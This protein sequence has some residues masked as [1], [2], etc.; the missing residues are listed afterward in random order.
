MI[1]S[2]SRELGAGGLTVGEAIAQSLGAQLIDERTIVV[3]LTDRLGLNESYVAESTERPRGGLGSL[4]D[5]ALASAQLGRSKEYRPS[6]EQL[7]SA[8][9]DL[10]QE[11]AAKGDVVVIGHGG[12]VLLRPI[13]KDQK[14]MI[15]LYAGRDWRVAQVAQRFAID[16]AEAQRRVDRVDEARARYFQ[17]NY[18]INPYE[19]RDFDLVLNTETLGLDNAVSIACSVAN[20]VVQRS[21]A[22]VG[23]V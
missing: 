14:L 19:S 15:M 10:I 1:V 2:I 13:P 7:L 11:S 6:D 4:L 5:V 3:T 22:T 8:A 23:G 21:R 16:K 9:R 12:P 17:Q 20:A 18:R